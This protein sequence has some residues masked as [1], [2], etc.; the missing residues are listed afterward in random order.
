MEFQISTDAAHA[1]LSEA[2]RSPTSEVCGLLLGAGGRVSHVVSAR[3]V[4]P[5][6]ATSF[7]VD[8]AVLLAAHRR[9]RDGK[10][11]VI[12]CYHSHPV[13]PPAPSSR[14]GAAASLSAPYWIIA[15]PTLLSWWRFN[16]AGPFFGFEPVSCRYLSAGD[17]EIMRSVAGRD[18]YP[19]PTAHQA[20]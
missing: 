17:T 7:E 14:D 1:I 16:E 15:T 18:P 11:G 4:A 9:H 13:G 3:N 12:G 8:P 20:T 5:D 2:A 10:P 19:S 6:P